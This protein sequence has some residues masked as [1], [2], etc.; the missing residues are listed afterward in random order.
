[1]NETKKEN[2]TLDDSLRESELD[3]INKLKTHSDSLD[4]LFDDFIDEHGIILTKIIADIKN[5]KKLI[6]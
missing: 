2:Q 1:M 5:L 4:K 6:E 3:L